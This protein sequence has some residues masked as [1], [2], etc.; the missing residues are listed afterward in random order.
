MILEELLHKLNSLHEK[1]WPESEVF[2]TMNGEEIE[3]YSL[4][5]HLTNDGDYQLIIE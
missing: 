2:I 5:I 1:I 3:A 4:E